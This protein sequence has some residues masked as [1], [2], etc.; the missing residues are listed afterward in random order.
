MQKQIKA[1]AADT[2]TTDTNE[3]EYL[4]A[5]KEGKAICATMSGK[6]W[7][8]GDLATQVAKVYGEN[9]LERFAE[10][11]NFPGAACTLGRYRSVCLAFPKTGGRPR[12][13]ASAQILQRH[14]DGIQIVT[15]NPNISVRE[16]RELMRKWRAE[17]PDEDQAEQDDLIEEE[18][19]TGPT[20]GATTSTPAKGAKAKGA[21][22]KGD[23]EQA[24][25]KETRRVFN[26]IVGLANDGIDA[27]ADV[28]KEERSDLLKVIEPRLVE[29][30]R[31]G[32]EALIALADWLDELEAPDALI[33]QGHV[34]TSPKPAPEPPQVTA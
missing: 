10:D 33:R 12:F 29:E 17:H 5:V 22:K 11:I 20:P 13:F 18:G 25:L 3:A 31:K 28:M 26:I 21:K 23:E 14:D 34:K 6:Q 32:G 1:Q 4:A 24:K 9:R 15:A 27:A 30:V 8:L 2:T 16:A 7:A 19:D